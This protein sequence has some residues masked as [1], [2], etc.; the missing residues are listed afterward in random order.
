MKGISKRQSIIINEINEKGFVRVSDLCNKFDVSTVT[1]RKDLTFLE[2]KGLLFRT[3]GG[4]SKQ[5]LYAFEKNISEKENIQTEQKLNI[6]QKALTFINEEDFII[7]ASGTTIQSLARLIKNYT[8][9]TVLTSSLRVAIELCDAP[10]IETIQLGGNVR[11]S[12]NSVVG[13]ISESILQNFS[14]N[15]LFL[16]V[17][18]IDFTFGITTSNSMEAHLNK[19]M[20]DSAEKVIV[21]ADSSKIGKRGFGK[22]AS[23]EAIDVLITDSNISSQDLK[24]FEELGI[25]VITI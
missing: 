12:S 25:E 1:I 4:A 19:I 23:I 11:K 2:K 3:H 15:K 21:L 22:I 8:K 16:G 6:S 20:I 17:D 5:S 24:T 14:C 18:G 7:L 9:L 10:Y 13:P